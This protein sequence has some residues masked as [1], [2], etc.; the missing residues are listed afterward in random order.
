MNKKR[1]NISANIK[2]PLFVALSLTL[3]FLLININT[4]AAIPYLNNLQEIPL[5]I[6]LFVIFMSIYHSSMFI[7]LKEIQKASPS[8]V[9]NSLTNANFLG[10]ILTLVTAS[11]L[12]ELYNVSNI[13]HHILVFAAIFDIA[14]HYSANLTLYYLI[15]PIIKEKINLFRTKYLIFYVFLAVSLY[16]I[17]NIAYTLKYPV[18]AN[19]IVLFIFILFSMLVIVYSSYSLLFIS[20]SYAEIGFVRKPFFIGGIGMI[21][22]LVSVGLIVFYII[23]FLKP[24]MQKDLYYNISLYAIFFVFTILYIVLFVIEY[25]SLL[26]PKWKVLMPFDLPKVTAAITIAFLAT[27]LYF[28]AKEYPNFIIYQNIS[29]IFVI[30]FLLPVFLGIILTFTYLKTLSSRTKLRYWGY[31]KH[32]LYIHL[33]VIFY[34]FS[35]VFLSWDNAT[36]STKMLFAMFGLASFAY[37]MFFALD[38]RKIIKDQNI[39]PIFDRLDIF[40]YIVSLFSWFFLIF[41]ALSFTYGRTFE[42]MGNRIELVPYPVILFFVAF[43]LIAF[44]TYLSVTHKG[45]EEIMRKNIWSELSYISAFI[46]FL[47]VYLIYSSLSTY[48]QRFPYHDFFFIGF[49]LV[50]IIEIASIRTLRLESR[51][52]KTGEEDIVHLLNFHAHNF[53]RT[54]YLEGLWEK[55]LDR[56]VREGEVTGIGFDPSGRRFD[57]EKADVPTRLKIAVAMLLGMHKLQDMEKIAIMKKSIEET[58]GD[59]TEI[60]KEKIL[61]LP[62]D[63]RHE[64]DE[65]MY[66][67]ILYERVVNNLL[68]RLK[69][70]IPFSEQKKIFNR[71]KRRDEKFKCIGVED[72]GIEIK[73]EARFSRDEFLKLFKL[74]LES[75]E[76]KFPFKRFLLHEL[77]REEIKKELAPYDIKISELIDIVPTGLEEMDEIMAGGLSKGSSTLL[78][79]EETKAKQK[80]LL[81]FIEQGLRG[82]DIVICAT[83]KR[84]AHQII[85]ELLMDF[86]ELNNFMIID[87]Y[88][89][90]Y[91]EERVYKLVEKEQRLTVPLNKTLFQRSIVKTIKSHPKEVSKIVVI[92]VYDDFSRYYSSKDMLEILEKQVEGL[93]RWNCTSIIALDPYSYLIRKEGIEEVKKNFDNVMILSGE[94][95]D[96][97][98]F[99]EKLYHGTPSKHILRLR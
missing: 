79:A 41:F 80:M 42:V 55:T 15:K 2:K 64:F 48:I 25:P 58:K 13:G 96:A 84:P 28:T 11:L 88:E 72:E 30:A 68:K 45:F 5:F 40:R 77:I 73:K 67:P 9:W 56:Y 39:K 75:V 95:K 37:Y 51:Y 26:Q 27:S 19:F 38:W 36:S 93:K 57:L 31:L 44:I 12:N 53:L 87:L 10:I 22:Y 61:V 94:D 59:I 17:A 91:T 85:G 78:I 82:R 35:L 86:D 97:S 4:V 98:V 89:N 70:F 74:Y 92:D 81:S 83:S 33:T 23:D 50:L 52:K 90:I 21:T 60:L 8:D 32:G 62:E 16:F 18:S 63:L 7:L 66:Y 3:L 24:E 43:F 46:A 69:A 47:L 6:Q 71:L 14:T 99:I 1:M 54:D 49:F 29:Y 20:K 34:A 65:S 76:E